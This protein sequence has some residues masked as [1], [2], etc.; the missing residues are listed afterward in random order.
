MIYI[1]FPNAWWNVSI[2]HLTPK[3]KIVYTIRNPTFSA[4]RVP[5][6]EST[7]YD[8]FSWW[9]HQLFKCTLNTIYPSFVLSYKHN[10]RNLKIFPQKCI[11]YVCKYLSI[12]S[13]FIHLLFNAITSSY[14][15]RISTKNGDELMKFFVLPLYGAMDQSL[16]LH[17][18]GWLQFAH[19]YILLLF[20]FEVNLFFY[21]G[22]W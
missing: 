19:C 10:S 7:K 16:Q 11:L 4:I 15:W 9:H 22:Q 3:W 13:Y 2:Y 17:L 18:W 1:S 8:G 21:S 14:L 6:L 5:S 20:V 12:S